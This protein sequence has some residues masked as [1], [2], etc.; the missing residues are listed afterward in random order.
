[1]MYGLYGLY[2]SNTNDLSEFQSHFS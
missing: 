2:V 1:M